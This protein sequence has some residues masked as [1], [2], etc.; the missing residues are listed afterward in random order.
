MRLLWLFC[1]I[2]LYRVQGIL[3]TRVHKMCKSV[4]ADNLSWMM[5]VIRRM[6]QYRKFITDWRIFYWKY[7]NDWFGPFWRSFQGDPMSAKIVR[8]S[9]TASIPDV[10]AKISKV[11]F[12]L[13]LSTWHPSDLALLIL[14]FKTMLRVSFFCISL[15][16]YYI[17]DGSPNEL[18]KITINT[19]Q[20][21]FWT[22][23]DPIPLQLHLGR[24]QTFVY[25]C[26]YSIIFKS[27]IVLYCIVFFCFVLLK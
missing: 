10:K 18:Q 20:I 26:I 9:H 7:R 14:H 21:D 4:R 3:T 5:D 25:L 23:S 22:F 6:N 17:Y 1:I 24:T 19:I 15:C 8:I 13:P 11:N 2:L 12:L 27:Y 16:V